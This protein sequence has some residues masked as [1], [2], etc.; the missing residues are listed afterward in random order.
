MPA[1]VFEMRNRF[2]SFCCYTIYRCLVS[3]CDMAAVHGTVIF[4]GD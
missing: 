3:V 1:E 2:E 4:L